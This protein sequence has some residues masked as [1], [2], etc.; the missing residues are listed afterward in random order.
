M[1]VQFS[2]ILI[3]LLVGLLLLSGCSAAP[4]ATP[5]PTHTPRPAVPTSKPA[6]PTA[7]PVAPAP[8]S[9][10][11]DD[12]A[13]V[14]A[15]GL[16]L[17]GSSLDNPPY[18][19]VNDQFRPAGFDVALITE[20][21]RRLGL[22]TDVNDFVFE[23][24]LDALQLKQVDT[25]IAAIDITPDRAAQ[26]DFSTPYYMGEDGILAAP[27][28]PISSVTSLADL[29]ER[30]IGVQRGC[31]LRTVAVEYDRRDRPDAE[32]EPAVVHQS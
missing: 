30:R 1:S 18:S 19:T 13:R 10:A 16:L 28:S 2:K 23:G 4:A 25:A 14:R 31:S 21:G 3:I 11:P 15:D 27:D 5:T 8:T 6:S 26:V 9:F 20:I 7:E 29:A 12:L 17:V 22:R 24:L 32:R